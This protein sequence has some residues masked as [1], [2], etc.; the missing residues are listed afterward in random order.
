[1]PPPSRSGRSSPTS[2]P[3]PAWN[4][5]IVSAVGRCRGRYHGDDADA[6]ARRA[7]RDPQAHRP[8]GDARSIGCAGE[9]GSESPGCSTPST[10]S[11]S[12]HARAV[13]CTAE[14][15]GGRS[16]GCWCPFMAG[17]LDRHTLPAVRDD[18]PGRSRPGPKRRWRRR[19]ADPLSPRA[20]EV[21]AVARDLLEA[22]GSDALTMRRT[23]RAD[24][25]PSPVP[26]QARARTR[27]PS[28]RRSSPT[29]SRRRLW[30]SKPRPDGAAD[31]LAALVDA[32]PS[33]RRRTI[34][35]STG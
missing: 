5:F 27:R 2:L 34:R 35:T 21:V 29:G 17:S 12:R 33:V 23:G 6:A 28:K 32:V 4:P 3:T 1:M 20:R 30:P 26:V 22:E 24:G 16:P 14:P 10:S 25:H 7:R 15:G 19:V 31:P 18:E 13:G 11:R 8:G 9:A